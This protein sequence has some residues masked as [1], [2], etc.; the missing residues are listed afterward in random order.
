VAG[1]TASLLVR[2]DVIDNSVITWRYD[3]NV[4]RDTEGTD[5]VRTAILRAADALLTESGP[6]ALT[7]RAIAERAGRST[8]LVYSR[9]GGKHGVVDALYVEGFRQLAAVMRAG[10]TTTDPIADLRRCG[11]AYR[12]FALQNPTYYSIMFDRAIPEF[13]PSLEASVIAS[14]TLDVLAERVQRAIDAGKLPKRNAR[15][16]AACLWSTN[17]GVVSLELKHVGPPDVNWQKRH[18]EVVDAMLAGIA[19]ATSRRA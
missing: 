1:S 19:V 12:K 10:R 7:V 18:T 14:A 2:N 13:E 11:L 6:D 16:I 8:M 15:E 3:V 9:F 4:T 17:H 5:E